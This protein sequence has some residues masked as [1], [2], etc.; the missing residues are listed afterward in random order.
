MADLD[1]AR[2]E[3]ALL[4]CAP[5]HQGGHSDTGMEISEVFGIGFP[6][7]M[8]SL[9]AFAISRGHMPYDLWPWLERMESRRNPEN[10]HADR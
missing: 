7:S 10:P 8:D 6:L 9:R 5:S 3:R 2:L 1:P 4:M